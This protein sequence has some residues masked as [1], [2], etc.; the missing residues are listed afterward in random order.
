MRIQS[1]ASENIFWRAFH[2]TDSSY[3]IGIQEGIISSG[4]HVDFNHP[5]QS[6]LKIEIKVK[7]LNGKVLLP[8]GPIMHNANRIEINDGFIVVHKPI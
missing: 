8:P 3:V 6:I 4:K 1:S 2:H 7:N 5:S